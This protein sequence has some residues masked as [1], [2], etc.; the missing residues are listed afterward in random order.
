[1][2]R[3][4]SILLCI[5]L[6]VCLLPLGA[7]A[8]DGSRE[9][10]F[11]LTADG[12]STVTASPGQII[13]LTLILNRTDSQESADM[14][15]VQ[16]ELLYDSTFLELVDS[17]VMT[18]P[19]VEW[20]DM[21]RRTGGRA[22]YLNFLSR[23]GGES[24]PAKVQLGSFQ[25][26]VLGTTGTSVIRSE[27][28]LV[29]VQDGSQSF[30]ATSNDVQVVVSTACTVRF[31][32]G[33]GSQVADQT[34]QYGELA[35]EPKEPTRKGYR[36]NG[37]Y[38][39]LDRTQ[40]WDF[41]TDTVQGNMTLYA[42]WLASSDAGSAFFSSQGGFGWLWLILG[43]M[44]LV[45]LLLLLLLLLGKKKVTF[46]SQGGTPLDPVSVKKGDKLQRPMTPVRAGSMFLGWFTQEQGGRL[47]NFDQDPVEKSMTLYAHWR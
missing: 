28:C 34:V 30:S 11:A 46:D 31:E 40:L 38:S 20:T 2:K 18:A 32:S 8:A 44:T 9:Y 10:D 4:C 27:N 36:F 43:L 19:S 22:F 5:C 45:A 12:G 3:I 1:M 13:T 16:A 23:S 41:A 29:S 17:S 37:W 6:L 33:G 14:Y 42:G 39:D 25:M 21:A 35:A 24:W 26:K 7:S 15:A 47:W